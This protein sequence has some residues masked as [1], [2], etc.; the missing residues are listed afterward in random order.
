MLR[1]LERGYAIATVRR[2]SVRPSVTF[3]YRDHIGWNTS[4]IIISR[5]I[6]FRF[7]LGPTPYM[8]D[9]VQW[10]HPQN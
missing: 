2:P 3:R 1:S 4:K 8:D 9:L 10:E 7:L 6:C 5:P